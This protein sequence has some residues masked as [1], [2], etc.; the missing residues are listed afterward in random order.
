MLAAIRSGDRAAVVAAMGALVRQLDKEGFDG[1][2]AAGGLQ[3]L[4]EELLS[5]DV[6]RKVNT[7]KALR[8]LVKHGMV[9]FV[10]R[11]GLVDGL[12][13]CTGKRAPLLL[14]CSTNARHRTFCIGLQ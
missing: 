3:Q 12:V 5:A 8:A 7:M 14:L 10:E 6:A 4:A 13:A 1:F 2:A 9:P 11:S